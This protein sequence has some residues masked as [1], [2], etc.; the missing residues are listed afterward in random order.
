VNKER[1]SP[2]DIQGLKDLLYNNKEMELWKSVIGMGEL[3]ESQ[4]LDTIL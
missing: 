4:A 2:T 3:V 1:P